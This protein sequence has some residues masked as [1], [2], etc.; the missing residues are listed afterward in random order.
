MS[1]DM[2]GQLEM[3]QKVVDEVNRANRKICVT[4]VER[5]KTREFLCSI[6]IINKD[7]KFQQTVFVSCKLE[8][9]IYLRDVKNSVHDKIITNEPICNV[10]QKVFSI[11]LLFIIAHFI[12]VRKSWNIG[13]QWD[14]FVELNSKLELYCIVYTTPETFS[15]SLLQLQLKRNNYRTLK[16]LI[17]KKWFLSQKGQYLKVGEKQ[18]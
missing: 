11:Y 18:V 14:F 2:D 4:A 17:P 6:P 16:R 13:D 1:K 12:L 5:G 10:L 8:E 7:E 3:A 9:F 15:E